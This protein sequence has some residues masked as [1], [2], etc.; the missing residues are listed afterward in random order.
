[1]GDCPTGSIFRQKIAFI[2]TDLHINDIGQFPEENSIAAVVNLSPMKGLDLEIGIVT[3]DDSAAVGTPGIAGTNTYGSAGT[4]VDVN[5]VWTNGTITAGADIM[6]FGQ[7]LDPATVFW[8]GTDL[9]GINVK[10]RI[11][12]VA[13]DSGVIAGLTDATSTTLYAGMALAKNLSV[14]LEIKDGEVAGSGLATVLPSSV[15]GSKITAEFIGTF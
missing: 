4:V 7:L 12:S 5:A 9:G 3:Q 1:M 2:A 13:V 10:A 11:E 14:A 15:E 6:T 8:V